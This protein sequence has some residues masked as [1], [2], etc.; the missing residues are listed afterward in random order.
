MFL[1]LNDKE[2]TGKFIKLKK[3]MFEML[4]RNFNHQVR[5]SKEKLL[6]KTRILNEK[7]KYCTSKC[8]GRVYYKKSFLRVMCHKVL[9]KL[10]IFV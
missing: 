5:H 10:I 3:L 1:K 4:K 2:N 7:T 9:K 6:R 8:L